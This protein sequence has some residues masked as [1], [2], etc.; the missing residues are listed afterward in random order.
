[1]YKNVHDLFY[2]G[3]T[4]NLPI[5]SKHL[6]QVCGKD[7][8]NIYNWCDKYD[9]KINLNCTDFIQLVGSHTNVTDAEFEIKS[10]IRDGFNRHFVTKSIGLCQKRRQNFQENILTKLRANNFSVAIK[11]DQKMKRIDLKG[12]IEHVNSVK[13]QI[14]FVFD[15]IDHIERVKS[16]INLETP[17]ENVEAKR[18]CKNGFLRTETI[19]IKRKFRD[20]PGFVEN[21][22]SQFKSYVQLEFNA[23]KGEIRVE[24]FR[25]AI[26]WFKHRLY[27]I[28]K[29]RFKQNSFIF[30]KMAPWKI[31]LQKRNKYNR[32]ETVRLYSRKIMP[33]VRMIKNARSNKMKL[34]SLGKKKKKSE[35]NQVRISSFVPSVT[36]PVFPKPLNSE[37]STL[38]AYIIFRLVTLIF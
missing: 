6:N 5:D 17:D 12:P 24:G 4:V 26:N 25:K 31:L 9:I 38:E 34:D 22:I 14:G 35:R 21:L 13:Q 32:N 36:I 23:N 3:H 16:C 10:F 15:L 37:F 1:M 2:D 28:S 27:V 7:N 18:K 19:R 11:I 29:R 20:E 8:K 30:E 33:N